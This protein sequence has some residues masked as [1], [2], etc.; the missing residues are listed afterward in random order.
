MINVL[1]KKGWF[2]QYPDKRNT[3]SGKWK[4]RSIWYKR[5][6]YEILRIIVLNKPF[7]T[8]FSWKSINF[9]Q[10]VFNNKKFTKNK[11]KNHTK[12]E[13]IPIELDSDLRFCDK[14][15]R[16]FIVIRNQKIVW[17][18]GPHCWYFRLNLKYF[19]CSFRKYIKTAKMVAFVRNCLVKKTL[20]LF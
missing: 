8:F 4:I 16:F 9:S 7:I 11:W 3:S 12:F 19:G 6:Y 18:H 20:R 10:I 13:Q 17:K 2:Y 14:L 15:L 5:I 1:F